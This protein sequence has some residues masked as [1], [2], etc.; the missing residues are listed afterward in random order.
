MV[1]RVK[2]KVVVDRTATFTHTTKH[3]RILI[4]RGKCT[5]EMR[6][7]SCI[8]V[9][10]WI[11]SESVSF[12]KLKLLNFLLQLPN[13]VLFFSLFLTFHLS[14]IKF[15]TN[16]SF[17]L[18]LDFH[19]RFFRIRDGLSSLW[20]YARKGFRWVFQTKLLTEYFRPPTWLP[21]TQ[22]PASSPS[23]FT[24]PP[25][26]CFQI[27]CREDA[28]R[29]TVHVGHLIRAGALSGHNDAR[30]V[31]RSQLRVESVPRRRLSKCSLVH[32]LS[33]VERGWVPCVSQVILSFGTLMDLFEV[34]PHRFPNFPAD[35]SALWHSFF[36]VVIL[37]RF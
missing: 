31:R 4:D 17:F 33:D 3:C 20:D 34:F 6:L 10:Q 9:G 7:Q 36:L 14:T 37:L 32:A 22:E 16:S 29:S 30:S 15:Q 24:F 8:P 1:D 2:F 13:F 26:L 28:E 11:I 18:Y 25:F 21:F 12:F 35:S 19:F 27:R 5:L 23:K